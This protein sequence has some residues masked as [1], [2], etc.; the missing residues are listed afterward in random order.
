MSLKPVVIAL[1]L[2]ALGAAGASAQGTGGPPYSKTIVGNLEFIQRGVLVP[3][4]LPSSNLAVEAAIQQLV[5]LGYL[6]EFD[7]QNT[8]PDVTF[9]S[10]GI[11]ITF[12]VPGGP[13]ITTVL[14]NGPFL[15]P[16]NLQRYMA[17]IVVRPIS[18]GF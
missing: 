3:G 1:A 15:P 18:N 14:S 17:V 8:N 5:Q 7:A 2:A 12:H 4:P 6:T 9:S 13:D 11:T 16:P 10:S